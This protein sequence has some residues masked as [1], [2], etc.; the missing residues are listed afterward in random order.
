MTELTGSDAWWAEVYKGPAGRFGGQRT[1]SPRP[2][3]RT[4][5]TSPTPKIVRESGADPLVAIE[6]LVK[7]LVSDRDIGLFPG[8]KGKATWKKGK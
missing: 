7:T 8:A 5:S 6:N 2:R 1:D 4:E 3:P